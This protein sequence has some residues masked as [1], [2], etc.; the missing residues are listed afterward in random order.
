MDIDLGFGLK[1]LIGPRAGKWLSLIVSLL[2][3]I[4]MNL[5]TE[6]QQVF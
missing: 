1:G 3:K 4:K 2:E 6:R 5:A